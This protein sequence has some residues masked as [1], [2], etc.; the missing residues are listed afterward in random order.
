[1][2]VGLHVCVCV[3]VCVCIH[4]HSY[5]HIPI[6]DP[7]SN[8]IAALVCAGADLFPL[9]LRQLMSVRDVFPRSQVKEW[10]TCALVLLH[11][12]SLHRGQLQRAQELAWH[13]VSVCSL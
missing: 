1:M 7:D 4:V 13:M 6:L 3:C 12:R 10:C 8:V 9:S 2:C 5:K 11:T